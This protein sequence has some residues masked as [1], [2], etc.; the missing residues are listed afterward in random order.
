[1]VVFAINIHTHTHLTPNIYKFKVL[2]LALPKGIIF[3]CIVRF[4]ATGL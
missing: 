4:K 3:T 1:M 2:D